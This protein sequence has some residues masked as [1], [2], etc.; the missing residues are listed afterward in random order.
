MPKAAKSKNDTTVSA[1][2]DL[3]GTREL[4]KEDQRQ[5]YEALEKFRQLLADYCHTL[6]GSKSEIYVFSDSAFMQADNFKFMC[7]F[8]CVLRTQLLVEG[9]YFKASV[10]PGSLEA[11]EARVLDLVPVPPENLHGHSFGENAAA[12]FSAQERLKGIGVWVDMS[13]ARFDKENALTYSC[14]LPQINVQKAEAYLD[15]KLLAED[16]NDANLDRILRIFFKSKTKSKKVGRFYV[17]LLVLWIQSIDTS[18]LD[19]YSLTSDGGLINLLLSGKFEKMF[20]DVLGIENIYMCFLDRLYRDRDRVSV[21]L[22]HDARRFILG[23]RR[24]I[25]SLENVPGEILSTRSRRDFLEDLSAD[26]LRKA[27]ELSEIIR[28]VV[29]WVGVGRSPAEIAQELNRLRIPSPARKKWTSSGIEELV[30]SIENQ[31][32]QG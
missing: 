3:V 8:L 19:H 20:G 27:P 28:L 5:Y 22:F 14:F 23:R 6:E 18:S 24:L 4:A 29:Q 12:L 32:G 1:F 7:K 16:L 31:D 2:I 30:R 17:S 15:I 13:L 25:R 21:S 11:R 9:L 26:L 10:G